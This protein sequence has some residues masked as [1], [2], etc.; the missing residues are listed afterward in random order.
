M[1]YIPP[2]PT[3]PTE[4]KLEFTAGGRDKFRDKLKESAG[5]RHWLNIG[6]TK[7]EFKFI[8]K[9]AFG[10]ADIKKSMEEQRAVM[11]STVSAAFTDMNSLRDSAQKLV[12][13]PY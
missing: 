12:S 11:A 10:L 13:H 8:K 4:I 7:E 5:A 2:L 6:S 1:E 3:Y 9:G